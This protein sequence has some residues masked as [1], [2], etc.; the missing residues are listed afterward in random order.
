MRANLL[1]D[2]AEVL[3]PEGLITDADVLEAH[4][5]DQATWTS[6]GVPHVLARPSSTSEVQ[7]VLRVASAHRVP[8]VA[9]GAG[10]GL[11]GGANALDGCIVLSLTRMNRILE[12]DRRGLFAVVQ[13]GVINAALKTAVAEQGLWYAPDPASWEFSTIG[14][15][16]ATNAG[17]LCCVKYGVTGDAALGLEVVLAAGSVLRTGGRTVKNVAGYD[18]T[19]LFVGSEGTLGVITEATL[20]LRPRPPP[21]TTL[22]ASFPTLVGAGAAVTEIMASTRP[23]L[24]E[25]MDRAT[26]RAVEAIRPMGLDM[27]AAALLLARSDAG[28]EQGVAECARMAAACE[29]SGATFVAQSADEAEGELLLGARR[30][31]YPA[32]EKQGTTLLDDVGVP[33][34]RIADL[35]SAVE[36]I[37]EQRGVLIGTFGHAGDGNMHPTLVFDRNDPEAVARAQ[38][39]FEDILVVVGELGGTITGEHGVGVLKRAYLSRQLGSEAT[40]VHLAIKASLDPLGILNPGKML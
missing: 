18:L 36:R 2:L 6:A 40:R 32:L 26:V 5:R 35:L 16:L 25:L 9:R 39:A 33:L 17:G 15:N 7:G 19:R 8:V 22:V 3:P 1:G 13:P 21:A 10:S 27:D 29:A 12:I 37:A 34:S 4:R 38:A 23:S 14:G 24:L 11:S 28:G 31:A 20:R 30:F